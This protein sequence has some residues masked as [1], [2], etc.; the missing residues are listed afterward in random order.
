[1]HPR[2]FHWTCPVIITSL[3]IG[4][5]VVCRAQ[6]PDAIPAQVARIG[7]GNIQA[8]SSDSSNPG[9]ER[10]IVWDT[11]FG[12]GQAAHIALCSVA[13]KCRWQH[14]WSGSY[15]IAIQYMGSWSTEHDFMFLVTYDQGAE[16]QTATV[17]GLEKGQAPKF[18][19]GV[20]GAWIAVAPQVNGLEVN[21]SS[22]LPPTMKC[23][24][25]DVPHLR[26]SDTG[27]R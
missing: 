4:V 7:S 1:M 25:W 21:T 12:D 11:G 2:T 24:R 3:A 23:L 9:S 26:F 19:A 22:G 10:L 13:G 27:C 17:V 14:V 16:A 18:L 6:P 15:N 5:P 20:D 8:V